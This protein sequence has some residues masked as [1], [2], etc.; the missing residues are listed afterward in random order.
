M[1]IFLL[2]TTQTAPWRI[3]TAK[4]AAAQHTA[5]PATATSKRHLEWEQQ[6]ETHL[7]PCEP[8]TYLARAPQASAANPGPPERC[9]PNREREHVSAGILRTLKQH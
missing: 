7:T 3:G 6:H 1:E 8:H 9:S 4:A 5:T 2:V